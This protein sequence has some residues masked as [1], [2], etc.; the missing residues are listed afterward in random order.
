MTDTRKKLRRSV[1]GAAAANAAAA[2]T[3]A[4]GSI[5]GTA[6]NSCIANVLDR[7]LPDTNVP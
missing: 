1:V 7:P 6:L 5:A 4:C 2:G 3:D